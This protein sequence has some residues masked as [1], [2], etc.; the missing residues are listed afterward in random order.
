MSVSICKTHQTMVIH[1]T[2][3][4]WYPVQY[5]H[6]N[7]WQLAAIDRRKYFHNSPMTGY[8]PRVFPFIIQS[9]P[10]IRS[11]F[12]Q[13]HKYFY[14]MVDWLGCISYT[15]VYI[16]G[17][18]SVEHY[19]HLGTYSGLSDIRLLKILNSLLWYWNQ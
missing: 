6:R 4:Y 8:N 14:Y 12:V 16:S 3:I 1:K 7:K 17:V 19:H 2:C 10:F 9:N 15:C 18:F 5:F 13:K 11:L